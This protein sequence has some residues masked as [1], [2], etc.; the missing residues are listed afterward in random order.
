MSLNAAHP[1]SPS[2]PHSWEPSRNVAP[3]NTPHTGH[4]AQGGPQGRAQHRSHQVSLVIVS[5]V[6]RFVSCAF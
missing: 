2:R 4:H 6:L 3:V 1:A 5:H